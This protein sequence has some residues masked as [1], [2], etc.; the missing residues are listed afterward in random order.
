LKDRC[1]K[2]LFSRRWHSKILKAVCNFKLISF[3][4]ENRTTAAD[5]QPVLKLKNNLTLTQPSTEALAKI[6]FSGILTI[7]VIPP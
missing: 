5:K 1:Q 3:T 2:K 7:L 6:V 4:N